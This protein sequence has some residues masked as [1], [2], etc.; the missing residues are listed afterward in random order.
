MNVAEVTTT[1]EKE[2]TPFAI[3]KSS[4]ENEKTLKVTILK[5]TNIGLLVIKMFINILY[6][7]L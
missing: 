3:L 7:G 5:T 4:K 2:P 6:K 1:Y